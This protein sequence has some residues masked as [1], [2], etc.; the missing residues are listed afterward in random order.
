[1]WG[2][3]VLRF[4]P[5]AYGARIFVWAGVW[6][7]PLDKPRTRA[8]LRMSGGNYPQCGQLMDNL[9]IVGALR[10][11]VNASSAGGFPGTRIRRPGASMGWG[12]V[13]FFLGTCRL[14][15][16]FSISLAGPDR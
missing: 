3:G 4:E 9:P 10:A 1:M 11:G 6:D 12:R 7:K 13:G 8:F 15:D 5:A 2:V 14:M 16:I